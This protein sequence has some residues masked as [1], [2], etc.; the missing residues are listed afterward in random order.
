[1]GGLDSWSIRKAATWALFSLAAGVRGDAVLVTTGF[2][3]CNDNSDIRV[4][5]VDIKYDNGDKVIT[6]DVGGANTKEQNVTG[7]FTVSAYGQQLFTKE[8]DPCSPKDHVEQLCPGMHYSFL[9]QLSHI[10]SIT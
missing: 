6:F 8:F 10:S 1:M 9:W 3:N 5:R 4:N 2:N 7:I